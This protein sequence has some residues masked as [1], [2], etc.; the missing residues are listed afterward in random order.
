MIYRRFIFRG[1]IIAGLGLDY[2]WSRSRTKGLVRRPVLVSKKVSGLD[3]GLGLEA[4]GLDYNT[5]VLY[6]YWCTILETRVPNKAHLRL[7]FTIKTLQLS[8]NPITE[9]LYAHK[10]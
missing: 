4:S 6:L 9:I 2:F 1:R 7:N 3:L 8:S 10:A 5:G